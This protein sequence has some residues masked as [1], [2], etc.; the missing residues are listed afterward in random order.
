[1]TQT[2][3]DYVCV[4]I[5]HTFQSQSTLVN[6]M[7]LQKGCWTLTQTQALFTNVLL[8]LY[9]HSK[10]CQIVDHIH[11]P[12]SRRNNEKANDKTFMD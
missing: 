6:G 2:F 9:A 1:M 7:C 4:A 5:N 12:T 3:M 11:I 8:R 10:T